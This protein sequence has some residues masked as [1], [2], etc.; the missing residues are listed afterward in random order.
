VLE[1]VDRATLSSGGAALVLLRNML[2]EPLLPLAILGLSYF[3]PLVDTS[4]GT[5][6]RALQIIY[7]TALALLVPGAF[8]VVQ[9]AT[10][11]KGLL[12]LPWL[13][14]LLLALV[15]GTAVVLSSLWRRQPR[16]KPANRGRPEP[17]V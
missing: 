9:R 4:L 17:L 15:C 1:D 14:L 7:G 3:A 2:A 11:G 5:L 10:H 13:P 12:P 6:F 8:L 16:P